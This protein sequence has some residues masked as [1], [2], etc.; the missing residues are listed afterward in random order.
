MEQDHEPGFGERP[1]ERLDA[2]LFGAGKPVRH[3]D[4]R[5]RAG[6]VGLEQPGPQRDP[7]LGGELDIGAFH[8]DHHR[9]S[10]PGQ[11]SEG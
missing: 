3:R 10:G 9:L 4:G 6:P 11:T 2:V 8:H 7:A 5:V 1:G